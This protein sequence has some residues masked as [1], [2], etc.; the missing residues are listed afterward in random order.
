[1]SQPET[2]KLQ[3]VKRVS[4]LLRG[5]FRFLFAMTI[6]SL[7]VVIASTLMLPNDGAFF[8]EL[9]G[10]RFSGETLTGSVRALATIAA[11]LGLGL[12]LKAFY[13]LIRLFGLYAAGQIFTSA[14]VRELRQ[15]GITLMLYALI[16]VFEFASAL[17]AITSSVDQW[18]QVVSS[19]PMLALVC[20][21][22]V[23][24]VSWI[25]DVGRELR[26]DQDL[27]V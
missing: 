24:L 12:S 10:I 8:V 4:R 17:P 27:V 22:I 23:I 13:H 14:N 15:I 19:F 16:W 3:E 9:A 7:L 21:A 2:P 25:M 6:V 20:G 1:M 18:A 11:S 26:E 5:F